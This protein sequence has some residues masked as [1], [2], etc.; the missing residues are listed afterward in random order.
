MIGL[1]ERTLDWTSRQDPRSKDYSILAAVDRTEP[2]NITWRTPD[3]LDQHREGA[4]VGFGWMHDALTTPVRVDLSRVRA[5][6]PRDPTLFARWVY[7]MAR[8]IDEWPGEEDNGT[9][10]IAGAKIM[11]SAGLLG[12]YRWGFSTRALALGLSKGPAILGMPWYESMYYPKGGVLNVAG[13]MVGGHCILAT[14]YRKPGLVFPG[15]AAFGL[16]NSWGRGWGNNGHAWIKE[17]SL[18]YLLRQDGEACIP[19]RRSYGR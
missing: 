5:D 1:E 16:F 2:I 11:Q 18:A 19:V 4:C 7:L 3:P 8:R 17:S 12:E 10:V 9:S 13:N 14:K 6:V 15:E